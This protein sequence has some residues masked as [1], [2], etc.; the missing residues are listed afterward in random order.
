M[1]NTQLYLTIGIPTLAVLIG[2]LVNV[3]YSVSVSARLI[4][5]ES[6]IFE[7]QKE[8]AELRVEV[9][10]LAARIKSLEE[11]AGVLYRG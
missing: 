8:I 7:I 3:G 10:G 11:R 6:R 2:I 5:I 4:A 9:A 1:N